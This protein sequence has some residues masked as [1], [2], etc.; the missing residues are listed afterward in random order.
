MAWGNGEKNEKS[1]EAE[2]EMNRLSFLTFM[3]IVS[4]CPYKPCTLPQ[5]GNHRVV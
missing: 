5:G 2:G 1:E 3:H 4:A